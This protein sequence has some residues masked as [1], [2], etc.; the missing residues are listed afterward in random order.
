[1]ITEELKQE[2]RKEAYE[3]L[4]NATKEERMHICFDVLLPNT[5]GG[6]IYGQMTGNCKSPK[7]IE[8]LIE[9]AVEFNYDFLSEQ[10]SNSGIRFRERFKNFDGMRIMNQGELR[11]FSAIEI[12]ILEKDAKSENLIKYLREE[13]TKLEL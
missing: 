13:T 7:A 5:M 1:M 9:C 3:L 11:V 10:Y 12:Y 6:C 8:L 2:V 4:K